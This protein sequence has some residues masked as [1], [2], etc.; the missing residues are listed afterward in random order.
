MK[1]SIFILNNVINILLGRKL[2]RA[3]DRTVEYIWFEVNEKHKNDC[4]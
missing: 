3:L 2:Y 1:E 4:S